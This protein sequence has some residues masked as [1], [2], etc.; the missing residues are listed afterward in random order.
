M[1]VRGLAPSGFII[2]ILGFV[3]TRSTVT[4]AVT[5]APREFV[6]G[7]LIPLMLGL[8][9][10]VLGVALA[11]GSFEPWYV[12][13]SAIWC[14]LGFLSMFVLISLSVL[15][16]QAGSL[17][18]AIR[19]S[20]TLSNV[21]I[22]SSI[23]GTLTGMYAGRTKREQR[24]S[25]NRANRLVVLNRILREEVINSVTVIKSHA[26][27]LEGT[28]DRIERATETITEHADNISETI[29]EVKYLIQTGGDQHASL[30]RVAV[31]EAVA[32]SIET[33]RGQHPDA[34][35][36]L[37]GT[38]DAAIYAND[39]LEQVFCQLIGNAVVH[40]DGP[41]TV[42]VS[43]VGV[44]VEVTVS[45]QGGGLPKQ[46]QQLLETGEIYE[47]DDPNS[48][49]GLNVVR[50]LVES[51]GGRI[52]TSVTEEGTTVTLQFRRSE[53]AAKG[54]PTVTDIRTYG[55]TPPQLVTTAA[56]ALVAGAAMGGVLHVI[57]G[58]IPVIGALYGATMPA[59]GLV[60][61]GFHSVVFGLMYAAFLAAV[62][63]WRGSL[64]NHVL[65]A[66][67]WS[68]FLWLFAAG[69]VMAGW[70]R[71][72]GIDVPLPNLTLASLLGHVV[73]GVTLGAVYYGITDVVGIGSGDR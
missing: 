26:G 47:Y 33:I 12:R 54:T 8:G 30:A 52:D 70:L 56:S 11:V 50:L 69:I 66:L 24:E 32:G 17:L 41:V 51:Y 5:A 14:G 28:T 55:V 72:V 9:L 43:T 67:A 49:F 38:T 4:L 63:R 37:T 44:N 40:T 45:D 1:K 27:L 16:T 42:H 58:T 10:A 20:P 53:T 71:L 3:L 73:W 65:V 25:R 23:G 68:G 62:P 31:D 64:R 21:L 36:E 2:A 39:R 7:G 6:F 46:Q 61:H 34:D 29:E 19:S 57:A 15:G 18:D 60:A 13:T 48:G 22:G 35:I 59:V